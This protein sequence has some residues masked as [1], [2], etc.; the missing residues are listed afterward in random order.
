MAP[1]AAR[2]Q[3]Q[4]TR[5]SARIRSRDPSE[6]R[7]V[8]TPARSS[9]R[10]LPGVSSGASGAYGSRS[11]LMEAAALEVGGGSLQSILQRDAGAAGRAAEET[12]LPERT[13]GGEAVAAVEEEE[14]GVVAPQA[15]EPVTAVEHPPEEGPVEE[16]ARVEEMVAEA[17]RESWLWVKL[18]AVLFVLFGLLAGLG[19]PLLTAHLLNPKITSV[20]YDATEGLRAFSPETLRRMVEE[21]V[22]AMP[23]PPSPL[24]ADLVEVNFLSP[25]LGAVVDPHLTSPVM[26]GNEKWI[27]KIYRRFFLPFPPQPPVAALMSW[28]EAGDA[29]CAAPET[30]TIGH[31]D[32]TKGK[33]QLAVILPFSIYPTSLAVEHIPPSGTLDINSAPRWLE[34]WI[35]VTDIALRDELEA[36]IEQQISSEIEY[37]YDEVGNFKPNPSAFLPH[38]PTPT[39]LTKKELREHNKG[40]KHNPPRDFVRVGKFLYNLEDRQYIQRWDLPIDLEKWVQTNKVIIRVVQNYGREW[41]CMY[42]VRLIGSLAQAT[43]T[44]YVSEE[45]EA[46]AAIDRPYWKDAETT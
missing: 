12:Q 10:E 44:E 32:G 21:T 13:M 16:E 24:P 35:Q 43:V 2:R 25:I 4:P 23:P 31:N 29:W 33:A 8:A 7:S 41:T 26:K 1:K 9:I 34:L 28:E 36:K 27:T 20:V 40:N 3:Q 45:H 38:D 6:V 39:G 42:R 19:G 11:R 37:G 5:A 14:E 46:A 30:T 22:A 15:S 18:L 17:P